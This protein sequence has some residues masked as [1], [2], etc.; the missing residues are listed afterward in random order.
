MKAP[1]KATPKGAAGKGGAFGKEG[2]KF[3]PKRA[4]L[5]G[6]DGKKASK[7]PFAKGKK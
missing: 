2:K 1:K 5:K 4:G 3:P 7:S 6:D